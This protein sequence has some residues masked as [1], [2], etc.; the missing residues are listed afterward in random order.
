MTYLDSFIFLYR[1]HDPFYLQK[2]N[3]QRGCFVILEAANSCVEIVNTGGVIVFTFQGQEE[4][5]E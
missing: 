5:L 1:H 3:T 4:K 2:L